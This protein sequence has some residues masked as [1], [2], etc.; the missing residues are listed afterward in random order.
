VPDS[1]TRLYRF[2]PRLSR[3]RRV[4]SVLAFVVGIAIGVVLLDLAAFAIIAPAL[5]IA[6]SLAAFGAGAVVGLAARGRFDAMLEPPEYRRAV[7]VLA[8][9]DR[10]G[11]R[12]LVDE[13]VTKRP[14][15]FA[16]WTLRGMLLS[17]AGD[18]EGA[19]AAYRSAIERRP[20][21]WIGWSGAG[22]ALLNQGK[23][24]EAVEALGRALA[25]GA[26]WPA[27]RYQLG[28][29]LFLR[30]EYAGAAEAFGE[31]LAL[32]LEAPNVQL[33][34][35]SLR[36]WALERTGAVDAAREEQE[37]AR[38]LRELSEIGAFRDGLKG[39]KLS[40]V[41]RLAAWAVGVDT[42]NEPPRLG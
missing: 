33:V 2:E 17:D 7:R 5:G 15:A 30:G 12:A 25:L 6:G 41:G 42:S 35:R 28:L 39:V 14:R 34:A 18:Y 38:P 21:S 29:A 16:P 13:A 23:L 27:P 1:S 10:A 22:G 11:A 19:L 24:G 3:R 36:A 4:G 37:R 20:E 40:P 26:D 32:G 31:A 9:G 8:E